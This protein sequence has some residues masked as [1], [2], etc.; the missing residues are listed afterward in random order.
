MNK[1][2][3]ILFALL[4]VACAKP[5]RGFVLEGKINGTAPEKLILG[6]TDSLGHYRTDT[7]AVSGG[8]FRFRGGI[9]EPTMAT[10]ATGTAT[11]TYGDSCYT[12][13]WLEPAAMHFEA[14]GSNLKAYT[15]TGSAT[16][17]EAQ[18]LNRR[19]SFVSARIQALRAGGN[20]ATTDKDS[21]EL[22]MESLRAEY[23][24]IEQD[25]LDSHPASYLAP[26]VLLPYAGNMTADELQAHYDS[27][28]LPVQQSH[29]GKTIADEIRKLRAG[30]PG[31][32]ATL[33]SATDIGG[34][35][36]N[37]ADLRGKIVLLDF[38]ASWCAPC[39]ASNPHLKALYAKYHDKG[40]E[41]V[42]ISDDDRA[43]AKWRQA[44]EEDG[45]GAFHHVLRGL[46]HK[47]EG[48]FD[49]SNDISESY[50][51]HSLPTKILIGRD[52]VIIGR[53][54]GGGSTAEDMDSKLTGIF[55]F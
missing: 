9:A 45:I 42:C 4:C 21:A 32:V 6:Y 2:Y 17:S 14:T 36:F 37:L 16:D 7:V 10:L 47:P 20:Q 29:V 48:G 28:T 24:R 26:A 39:R 15:L 40:L 33:F 19:L 49:H 34:E 54:G 27:W 55:G 3:T 18:E 41:V 25:F 46:R 30:S 50:G 5:E 44:V 1:V 38:W 31:A 8:R 51:I 22:A 11:Y 35:T 13:L 12:R 43:P 53:Y 52:G 23:S